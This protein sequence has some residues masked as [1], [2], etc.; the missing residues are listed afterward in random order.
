[1]PVTK[2]RSLDEARRAQW[3]EGGSDENL[4][5]LAFVLSLWSTLRPKRFPP[6]VHKYRSI[7][8][9]NEAEERWQAEGDHTLER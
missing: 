8:E 2:F 7:E 3:S 1:M 5:R 9:A 6:G 4:R